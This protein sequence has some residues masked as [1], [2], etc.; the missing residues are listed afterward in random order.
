MGGCSDDA[1]EYFR[2]WLT[3]QG[4]QTF[5]R[6]LQQPDALAELQIAD[7]DEECEFESLLYVTAEVYEVQS[8]EA[9]PIHRLDSDRPGGDVWEFDDAN[10]IKKRLPRLFQAYGHLYE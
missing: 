5:R 1:F 8:G 4:Q 9:L 3:S 7:P 6:C 2:L 10:Q